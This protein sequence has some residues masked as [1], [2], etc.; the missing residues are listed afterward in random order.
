MGNKLF[1]FVRQKQFFFDVVNKSKLSVKRK[2]ITTIKSRRVEGH[3]QKKYKNKEEL[4]K[5]VS[6]MMLKTFLSEIQKLSMNELKVA[7]MKKIIN[8]RRER[9]YG[10]LLR[11]AHAATQDLERENTLHSNLKRF[12]QLNKN[13]RMNKTSWNL[14]LNSLSKMTIDTLV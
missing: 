11:A 7:Q 5:K 9:F 14:R 8:K 4:L 1:L 12:S 2:T 13:E 3:I 10:K 6:R